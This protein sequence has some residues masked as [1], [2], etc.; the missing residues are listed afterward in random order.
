VGAYFVFNSIRLD[1]WQAGV[2]TPQS[3]F[4]IW[5]GEKK[6]LTFPSSRPNTASIVT[7]ED[8]PT[9]L[10]P[11]L[12]RRRPRPLKQLRGHT[13]G[14]LDLKIN[15]KW[16]ASCSKD[17]TLALHSRET[18]ELMYTLSGHDGPVNSIGLQGDQLL[19]A[20]GDG[21]IILWG[22]GSRRGRQIRALLGH[23]KGLA[24]VIFKNDVILSG[25][26]DKKIKLWSASTGICQQTYTGHKSLVRALAYQEDSAFF[27]SASYDR[28][29]RVWS[30]HDQDGKPIREFLGQHGSQIFRVG[31]DAARIISSSHDKKVVIMDFAVDLPF[32]LKDAFY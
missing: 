8:E 23:E 27:V 26:N 14:V 16:I 22:L 19:S 15:E 31:A 30:M 29:V 3:L 5:D 4:G 12:I 24:C 21:R 17:S 6:R 9:K 32:N 11:H 1:L 20:S 10:G 28:S 13:G 2:V 25:S 7:Q 18:L